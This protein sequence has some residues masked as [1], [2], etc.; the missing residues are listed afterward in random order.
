MICKQKQK[1]KIGQNHKKTVK[2]EEKAKNVYIFMYFLLAVLVYKNNLSY[3]SQ[4][5]KNKLLKLY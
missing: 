3:F 2:S 4:K 5:C 1:Q